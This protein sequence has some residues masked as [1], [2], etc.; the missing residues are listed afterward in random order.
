MFP[1]LA[2]FL[3]VYFHLFSSIFSTTGNLKNTM[4]KYILFTYI[5]QLIMFHWFFSS[6]STISTSACPFFHLFHLFIY[7]YLYLPI[8]PSIYILVSTT[9]SIICICL[10]NF[11]NLPIFLYT[12]IYNYIRS[13]L[14]SYTCIYIC[15]NMPIYLLIRPSIGV[16]WVWAIWMYFADIPILPSNTQ[17]WII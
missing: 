7:L 13:L 4:N 8:F 10:Y 16:G 3:S 12:C 5:H 15:V 1:S 6:V 17:V 9:V 14:Q 2:Q 11:F